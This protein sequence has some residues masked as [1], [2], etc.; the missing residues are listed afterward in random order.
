MRLDTSKLIK[1]VELPPE[2]TNYHKVN[3]FYSPEL[4]SQPEFMFKNHLTALK[5]A[6]ME[7]L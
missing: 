5:D 1:K 2:E 3:R 6:D 7:L 4:I